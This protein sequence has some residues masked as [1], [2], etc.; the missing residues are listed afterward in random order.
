MR[1]RY[2]IT[3]IVLLSYWVSQF[4]YATIPFEQAQGI[5]A[6]TQ[7][8]QKEN[9]PLWGMVALNSK[10]LERMRFFGHYNVYSDKTDIFQNEQ[11]MQNHLK[12]LGLWVE[13][14]NPTQPTG[15]E[16]TWKQVQ[17]VPQD[18]MAA[19]L[20]YLFPSPDGAIF[21]ANERKGDPLVDLVIN[22]SG[23]VELTL[24]NKLIER[25]LAF[26]TL[27]QPS[28]EDWDQLRGDIFNLLWPS[29]NT[30]LPLTT[31][32]PTGTATLSRHQKKH[33]K[34]EKTQEAQ[35]RNKK[36]IRVLE[37]Q[38]GRPLQ[39][40]E[41]GPLFKQQKAQL[42]NLPIT[43]YDIHH[44]E[45][46]NLNLK[47][48]S[49]KKKFLALHLTHILVGALEQEFKDTKTGY[50]P[51]NSVM[52]ALLAYVWKVANNKR[53][54]KALTAIINPTSIKEEQFSSRTYFEKKDSFSKFLQTQQTGLLSPEVIA[55]YREGYE[56]YEE[57][58][59]SLISYK[60]RVQ[61]KKEKDTEQTYPDC[62]ETSLRNFLYIVFNEKG[63]ISLFSLEQLIKNKLGHA[64]WSPPAS[65]EPSKLNV[66]P[67]DDPFRQ[68]YLYFAKYPST[69]VAGTQAAHNDWSQI[70]SD[71]NRK[72]QER[73]RQGIRKEGLCQVSYGS[74]SQC[75]ECE[76]DAGLI[77]MLN[78]IA[79][80]VPD[81]KLNEPWKQQESEKLNQAAEKLDRLCE[82]FSREGFKLEW[83]INRE[84]KVPQNTGITITFAINGRDAFE[85]DMQPMH[86]EIKKKTTSGWP[87]QI[88]WA[89]PNLKK[90]A[91]LQAWFVK[92]GDLTT[93]EYQKA[94]Q[95]FLLFGQDLRNNDGIIYAVDYLFNGQYQAYYPL[96]VKW[97]IP[98]FQDQHSLNQLK[99]MMIGHPEHHRLFSLPQQQSLKVEPQVINSLLF[100]YIIKYGYRSSLQQLLTQDKGL[101]HSKY[102]G[103]S[104]LHQAAWQGQTEIAKLLIEKGAN[105]NA[106]N[107]EGN[108]P[109]HFA[110]WEGQTETVKLL[111][112]KGA[113]VNA[114]N[115]EGNSPLHLAAMFGKT[116][117]VKLLLE[118]GANVNA[119]D[120]KGNT[121]LHFAA[122]QGKTET[123][124]LLLEKGANVNAQNEK[125]NTPLHEATMFGKT[126]IAKLLIEKGANVNAQNKNHE[127]PLH[128]AIKKIQTE[129]AK[130]LLE[131]GAN[132][133]AQNEKGNTPLHFT[134]WPGRT[135]IAKLLIE[136]GANVDAPNMNGHTP[137]H[138]AAWQ[139][140]TE[141]TKLLLEKGANVNAPDKNGDTPLHFAA[142]EGQT[143]TV[144]LLL[145]KG[146]NVDQNAIEMA[147]MVEIKALL[148]AALVK[149][150]A[151]KK[152]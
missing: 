148:E 109:L 1:Y 6:A 16:K 126:E 63:T 77:N 102:L 114:Q 31:V 29:L 125:G 91:L 56:A 5:Y 2:A 68:L 73:P 93:L 105:V 112:E 123:V 20:Q 79:N 39:K 121:P 58:I 47:N 140:E 7:E 88:S 65:Q 127:T 132:V 50:Y 136:K 51:P 111:I 37:Q 26:K 85:W 11:E 54:L 143:E 120:E 45:I 48:D 52:T 131:K 92:S 80:L 75:K 124:K 35:I 137:L 87:N 128:K 17:D 36:I 142:M 151:N 113:N 10:I 71:L 144:K 23:L 66:E 74:Y 28:L 12:V 98:L 53:D 150:K 108:T 69:S 122:W 145:E 133:N 119:Q 43:R 78:V 130:L 19:L 94:A 96:A 138:E 103:D 3:W 107:E 55:L 135:E 49:H 118:K 141:I 44:K 76:I 95:P 60:T 42:Q 25:I 13:P 4:A 14:R 134:V 99:A 59:P 81:Q 90:S 27:S 18:F 64:D 57:I 83:D 104:L 9:S 32:A 22:Q 34:T 152:A 30:H 149:Q 72:N 129:I 89:N 38:Q 33:L 97:L 24:F 147:E 84:R 110:A 82:L 101:I 8:G 100:N 106:Q 86:F 40:H 67:A 70:V 21:V 46:N 61:Y 41:W 117:T 139:G 15:V 115:E 62:G 146:A 116:E